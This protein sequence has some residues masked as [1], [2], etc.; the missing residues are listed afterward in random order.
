MTRIERWMLPDGVEEI[1][2]DEAWQIEELRRRLLDMF[3]C[4]GYDLVIPPMMEFADS[5]LQGVGADLDGL[6]FKVVDQMSG[7]T[8][9]IRS[10]MTP[11]TARMDAHSLKHEGLSRLCYSGHVLFARPKS[12]L[13]SRNPLQLGVELYG[14]AGIAADIEVASLLVQSLQLAGLPEISLDLGH[15]GIFRALAQACGLT[16]DQEMA[17]FNLLQAKAMVDIA[18]WVDI[19]LSDQRHAAW[20]LALPRLSG[21]IAVLDTAKELFQGAPAAV[22]AALDDLRR[23]ATALYASCP[24][25][26]I[27]FDLSEL[28]GYHYHTG[29]VF[30]AFAAGVGRE[31]ASGGRYDAIGQSFGRARP[32]TGFTVDLVLLKRLVTPPPAQAS[33][34][35]VAPDMA[36]QYAA[37]IQ[38]LRQQGERVVCASPSHPH[39]SDYLLCDRQLLE[40]DGK[41]HI[42][43]FLNS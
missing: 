35:F 17:L 2:P 1:L 15:V 29:M 30:A 7:G 41:P 40:V 13:A 36:S 8:L 39:Y 9:A 34:I 22:M 5:L 28:R 4:W 31:I 27:Y 25:L 12:L 43:T 11:Q 24:Q 6:T 14:E 26:H 38:Q 3:R 32:A 18:A 21:S 20:I 33:G 10:D 23:V 19:Q 37:I 16:P 42:Q